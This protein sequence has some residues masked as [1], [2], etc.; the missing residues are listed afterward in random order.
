MALSSN[1]VWEVRPA[2][3]SDTN[4]G[5][6]DPSVT[7]PGTDYSQQD[8]ANIA[9]TDLVIDASNSA[10]ATSSLNPFTSA[11]V[12]NFLNITSGT[13]FTAGIYVV[14]SVAAGVAT[15]DS[16]LGS[17]SSTGGHG[18][19]GGALASLPPTTQFWGTIYLKGTL[20][21][22]SDFTQVTNNRYFNLYGYGS[23]RGDNTQA[24][25]QTSTAS[26]NFFTLQYQGI[27]RVYNIVFHNTGSTPGY[28]FAGGGGFPAVEDACIFDNCV[29][30]GYSHAFAQISTGGP[31]SLSFCVF[32]N[33][34]MKNCT[35]AAVP[36]YTVLM[37]LFVGCYIHDNAS[38]GVAAQNSSSLQQVV[39]SD[40][41]IKGNAGRGIYFGASNQANPSISVLDCVICDN[42]SHGIDLTDTG[43]NGNNKFLTIAN[44]IFYANGGYGVKGNLVSPTFTFGRANAY[45]ANTSGASL[46]LISLPGDVTL[47]SDPFTNRTVGDFTLNSTAGGGAALKAAGYESTLF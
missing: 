47:T 39:F 24:T 10:K 35:G 11:H 27:I 21:Y 42:T 6:F 32:V 44:T 5:G 18:N 28:C 40:C 15:F 13:G 4:G 2:T 46:N 17:T 26:K 9:F 19:L 38:D 30:D 37:M 8:S 3:G 1:S 34:E 12:G 7:S 41:V 22:T 33:C 43:S 31:G 23:S 45:G 25:I 20:T 29:F 14:Q 36:I 16:S